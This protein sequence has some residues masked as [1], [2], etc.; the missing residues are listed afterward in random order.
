MIDELIAVLVLTLLATLLWWWFFFAYRDYR[1]A[2]LRQRLFKIRDNLFASAERGEI[3]FDDKAY[4]MARTTVN[5]M[6]RFAHEVSFLRF[7]IGYIVHRC[8]GDVDLV[9]D[10]TTRWTQNIEALPE[11][12]QQL[13]I[14]T[15]MEMHMHVL[16]HVVYTSLV[17]FLVLVPLWHLLRLIHLTRQVKAR[18]IAS[19]EW[20]A[21]RLVDAEANAIG[22]GLDGNKK[23]PIAA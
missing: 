5:G 8:A 1:I 3:S 7:L 20:E 21:W 19:R 17:G 4:G 22:A 2:L 9:R 10:F 6:I 18:L 13:V 14:K 11:S 16:A 15:Y 12:A 23:L